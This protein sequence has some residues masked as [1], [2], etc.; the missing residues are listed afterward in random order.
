MLQ[1]FRYTETPVGQYDELAVLPGA[2]DTPVG[3][4]GRGGKMKQNSRITGIWVSQKDTCWNGEFAHF[5]GRW[6][7]F[8]NIAYHAHYSAGRKN[9]NI[10]KCDHL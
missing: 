3:E 7:E 4:K 5:G 9:W 8:Q 6:S 1:L 2:F 10:P